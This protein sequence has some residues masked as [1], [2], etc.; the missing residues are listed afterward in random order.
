MELAVE[1]FVADITCKSVPAN[2]EHF[3]SLRG[4]EWEWTISSDSMRVCLHQPHPLQ[5]H[6]GRAVGTYLDLLG[7]AGVYVVAS[8]S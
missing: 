5:L 8:E 3:I 6:F 2:K 1:R 7:K 4:W